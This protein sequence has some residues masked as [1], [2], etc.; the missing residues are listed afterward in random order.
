MMQ[1]GE[2]RLRNRRT[3]EANVAR[4]IDGDEDAFR[5]L[6]VRH[7]GLTWRYAYALTGTRQDAV[8]VTSESFARTFTALRS[9]DGTRPDF[10]TLLLQTTRNTALD[11]RRA[12]GDVVPP[13]EATE[14]TLDLAV[15]FASLPERWRSALWLGIVEHQDP[16]RVAGII[17]VDRAAASQITARARKGLR[18][19]YLSVDVERG[20]SATCDRAVARLGPYVS[21][22]LPSSDIDKLERHLGLCS[23]CSDRYARL[24]TLVDRLPRLVPALPPMLEDDAR[25]AWAGA[26]GTASRG[27]GISHLGEKILAGVAAIAAGVGVL[28]AA[29]VSVSG[30]GDGDLAVAPIAPLVAELAAPRPQGLDLSI[31]LDPVETGSGTGSGTGSTDGRDDVDS[32]RPVSASNGDR[33]V[34]GLDDGADTGGSDAGDSAGGD[35]TGSD[36]SDNG[37]DGDG[38]P[39]TP[40]STDGPSSAPVVS[41]GTDLGG[42]PV[43]VEVGSDPG[44][45][46]GPISVGSEPTPG[47]DTI[48]V[49]GPLA[50]VAPVVE[51]VNDVL[52][53]LLGR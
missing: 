33:V 38:G 13:F 5:D 44:L 25:I 4:A 35:S 7:A 3:V 2:A 34:A 30:S 12:L 23:T 52:N 15:A 14:E 24:A 27:L 45:T 43:A 21:G 9:A 53:G 11:V 42:V 1:Q 36:G 37:S 46:V 39:S 28:G 40:P 18:E 22:T 50:P 32:I 51:P 41:V 47:G 19:Q 29:M 16:A 20:T 26:V 31:D 8:T 49:G 17:G 48:T 10:A 6:Y